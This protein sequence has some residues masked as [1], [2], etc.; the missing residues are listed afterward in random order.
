[1]VEAIHEALSST[2]PGVLE[3]LKKDMNLA[4]TRK[5]KNRRFINRGID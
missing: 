1:M 4:E 5:D 3:E 2:V